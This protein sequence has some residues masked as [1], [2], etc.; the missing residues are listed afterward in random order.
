MGDVRRTLGE[1]NR[2]IAAFTA[3]P[4]MTPEGIRAV[5]ALVRS[6]DKAIE[7]HHAGCLNIR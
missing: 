3:P 6:I 5:D 4:E 1:A 7:T 2:E